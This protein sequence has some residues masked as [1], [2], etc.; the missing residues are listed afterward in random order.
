LSKNSALPS[1]AVGLNG[2]RTAGDGAAGGC[3]I[4]EGNAAGGC[5][6]AATHAMQIVASS[7]VQCRGREQ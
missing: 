2:A 1:C 3:D 6:G 7:A 4:G 5:A